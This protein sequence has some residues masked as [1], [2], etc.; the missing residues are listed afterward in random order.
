MCVCVYSFM[1]VCIVA[2]VTKVELSL[3]QL[4]Q[5]SRL[6]GIMGFKF[7]GKSHVTG[8]TRM[9]C[10]M[11]WMDRWMGGWVEGYVPSKQL[12]RTLLHVSRTPRV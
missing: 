3:D 11:G 8:V 7:T 5:I 10:V 9:T 4:F 2:S 6:P 12:S 1:H